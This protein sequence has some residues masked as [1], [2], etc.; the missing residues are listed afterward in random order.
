MTPGRERKTGCRGSR[1][2]GAVASGGALCHA[3]VVPRLGYLIDRFGQR[4]V[5]RLL[6]LGFGAAGTLFAVAARLDALGRAR[7][8]HLAGG[9][10]GGTL[11]TTCGAPAPA[12][13]PCRACG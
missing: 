12:P 4:L 5:L 1:P 3:L 11:L 8:S 6:A 7:W 10:P 9:D 2:A 13:W